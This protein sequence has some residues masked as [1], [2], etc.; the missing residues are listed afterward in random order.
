MNCKECEIELTAENEVVIADD[1][2]VCKNCNDHT[3]DTWKSKK[4]ALIKD[5]LKIPCETVK[6]EAFEAAKL[7]L[8]TAINKFVGD[9]D[10]YRTQLESKL[11]QLTETINERDKSIEGLDETIWQLTGDLY[12]FQKER[13]LIKEKLEWVI[14]ACEIDRD[15]K[16]ELEQLVI[17]AGQ[18]PK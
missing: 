18:E 6:A 11:Y 10:V 8:Y 15:A 14:N 4:E 16:H 1:F 7:A 3:E 9:A 5:G 13:H 2:R 12:R 17:N